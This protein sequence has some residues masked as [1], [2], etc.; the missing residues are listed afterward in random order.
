MASPL[1]FQESADEI[2]AQRP[3][4]GHARPP[5]PGERPTPRGPGRPI[6]GNARPSRPPARR[7]AAPA[8]PGDAA[9]GDATPVDES[10]Q[11]DAANDGARGLHAGATSPAA[12]PPEDQAARHA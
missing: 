5:R 10:I 12:A 3:A 11:H 6:R 2:L 1:R 9:P 8:A 7:D 4:A